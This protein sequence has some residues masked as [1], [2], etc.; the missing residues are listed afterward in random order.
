MSVIL[1]VDIGARGAMA[2]IDQSGALLSVEDTCLKDGP[3]GRR[4]INAALIASLVFKSHADHAFVEHVSA[5]PGEGAVGAFAFGRA[6]GVIEGKLAAAGIPVP[7]H[8]AAR[9][10]T[11]RR[12]A[13]RPRIRMRQGPRQFVAGQGK[14]LYSHAN[15][16]SGR[17][18]AALIAVAG[19]QRHGS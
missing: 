16:I 15:A 19:V 6:R 7:V 13:A 12:P 14:P 2:I 18:E 8:H 10:E 3:A 11:K 5:R 4:A 1:G 9:L 17:A